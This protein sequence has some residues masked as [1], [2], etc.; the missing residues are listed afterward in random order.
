[1]A[2]WIEYQIPANEV[3]NLF[4]E[5]HKPMIVSWHK[6]ELPKGKYRIP[7]RGGVAALSDPLSILPTL[8]STESL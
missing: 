2:I 5:L 1:M 6:V 3:K 7:A 8:F 4:V